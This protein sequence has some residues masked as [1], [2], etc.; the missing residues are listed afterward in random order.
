MMDG[1]ASLP[2]HIIAF[3]HEHI[4]SLMALEV[5]LLVR[6]DRNR[7]WTGEELAHELRSTSEWMDRE[8]R[9]LAMRGLLEPSAASPGAFRFQ[10]IHPELKDA[11][12]EVAACY[13]ERRHTMIQVIYRAPPNPI[14]SFA[15]AFRLKKENRNG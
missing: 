14:Q 8:L 9:E 5:L 4:R 11:V 15:E 10:P 1:A 12:D 6:S 2:A 3:L 7:F 13:A